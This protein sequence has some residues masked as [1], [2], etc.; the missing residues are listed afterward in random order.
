MNTQNTTHS[1]RTPVKPEDMNTLRPLVSIV[2]S[3]EGFTLT[4]EM[5]G[6]PKEDVEV[7]VEN[8][9]LTLSGQI[10]MVTPDGME[11]TYTEVQEARYKR[12]FTLSRELDVTKIQA[13][14]AD[15]VLTLT[16]PK[17]EH[18]QPRKIEVNVG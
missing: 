1:N 11:A 3:D 8:D 14:Q 2:E 13:A 15:G 4:A 6:V 18:A 17:A 16:I 10:K 7:N 12:A 9:T 5:P